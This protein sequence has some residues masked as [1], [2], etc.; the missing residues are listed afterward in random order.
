MNWINFFEIMCYAITLLFLLDVIRKKS[1]NELWLFFSAAFAGFALE[2]LAVRATDIYHYSP[3][4]YISVGSAPYQFPFFGGLMWGGLTVYSLRIARKLQLS[5]LMTALVGGWLIVTMDLLLDVAAIRLNGG[6]WVW[7]GRKITLSITHHMF[8]SVIWVNFLGYLFETPAV[9]YFYLRTEDKRKEYPFWRQ[10]LLTLGIGC[11]GIAFVAAASAAALGLNLLTDEWFAC[12][13][14][15]L[16]WC[17]ILTRMA[18]QIIRLRGK[19]ERKGEA[20]LAAAGVLGGHVRILP[21]S[22][23]GARNP[24]RDARLWI[25]RRARGCGDHDTMLNQ[26]KDKQ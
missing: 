21:G 14:F 10:A 19:A 26:Y 1:W 12:I 22:A 3:D 11:L 6:F 20:Q 13:A 17:F 9:I 15:S 8:M 4:F 24:A 7:D 5:R 23:P 16:L 25:I 18:I 2:L